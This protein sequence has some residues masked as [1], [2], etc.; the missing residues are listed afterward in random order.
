MSGFDGNNNNDNENLGGVYDFGDY[1]DEGYEQDY[2][3]GQYPQQPQQPYGQQGQYPQYQNEQPYEQQQGG[4][5]RGPSGSRPQRPSGGKKSSKKNKKSKSSYRSPYEYDEKAARKQKKSKKA[6]SGKK[7][8]PIRTAI[9]V[10]LIIVIILF[11]IANLILWHYCG[12]VENVE[13]GERTVTD[14]SMHSPHVRNILIIGSDTRSAD[15]HGRTD[16]MILLSINSKTKEIVMTSFMRDMYVMLPNYDL[17]G[18]GEYFGYGDQSKMN[19]AYVYG[20]AELLMDTIEYNFDIEV[21]DY[22]YIDFYSFVDIVDAIGGITVDI[23]DEEAEGMKAPMAEQ[24]KIM[25]K[26]KGSDYLTHGGK[27]KLNG[28]QALAYARLRYVGNAD[29]ER[30]SRQREVIS[31]IIKKVKSGGPMMMLDFAGTAAESLRSNMSQWEL[32]TLSYKVLFSMNYK[33]VSVRIPAD[34]AY[35]YD[36]TYDGQSILGVDFD[37]SKA[38]LEKKI[39]DE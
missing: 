20:G 27:L 9:K 7:S 30:T 15:E 21:D 1:Y 28:N 29:F 31:K 18:D 39:Y 11:L 37:K 2:P 14:A 13:R 32:F 16:S 17:D 25:N 10:I 35:Y 26:E 8:H 24:N 4:Y 5:S 23:T 3:N 6:Y 34:D 36:T 22:V 12:L 38:L 19:A 33:I